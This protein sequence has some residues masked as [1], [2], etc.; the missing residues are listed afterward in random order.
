M[1]LRRP[2]L[3]NWIVPQ[4][5]SSTPLNGN[6]PGALGFSFRK[7]ILSPPT[8]C[9]RRYRTR[10]FM[11]RCRMNGLSNTLCPSRMRML[12]IR[13]PTAT[14]SLI[15]TSGREA[16]IQSTKIRT[17]II[18]QNCIWYRPRRNLFHSCF[19]HGSAPHLRSTHSIRANRRNS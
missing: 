1:R 15:S 10:R 5:S 4:S 17:L 12:S 2:R 8:V 9:R 6:P 3:L 11:P 16:P 7:D 19:H 13:I 14:A 18:S